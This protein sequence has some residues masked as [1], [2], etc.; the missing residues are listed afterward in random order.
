MPNRP[1]GQLILHAGMP[2]TG[3]SSIQETLFHGLQDPRFRYV[4]FG[5]VNGSR[6]LWYLVSDHPERLHLSRWQGLNAEAV[7]H[8]QGRFRQRWQHA[9]SRAR[10]SGATPIISAEVGWHLS[11]QDLVRV[12]E[13]VGAEGYTAAV[14]IYLRPMLS[15]LSSHWQQMT[16][17]GHTG[18]LERLCGDPASL[19]SPLAYIRRLEQLH[20]TFGRDHVSVRAFRREALE[21]GCVVTDFCRHLGIRM[22]PASIRRDNESLSLDATRFLHAYN[23]FHRAAEAPSFHLDLLLWPSLQ[24]LTGPPFRL[25]PDLLAPLRPTLVQQVD[26]LRARYGIDLHEDWDHAGPEAVRTEA[27]LFRFSQPSLEWLAEATG[28]A[29]ITGTEGPEVARQVGAQVAQ[30]RRQPPWRYRIARRL[31]QSRRELRRLMAGV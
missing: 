21:D 4:G 10:Q 11:G 25:H 13:L 16:K 26:T 6:A 18:D 3:T 7:A 31:Y 19:A 30:L 22:A 9:A 2:K 8:L 20:A 29:C 24:E 1:T 23:V 5:E 28:T 12:R 27:D 14:V 17:M 15:W